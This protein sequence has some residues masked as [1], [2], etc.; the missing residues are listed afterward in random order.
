MKDPTASSRKLDHIKLAFDSAIS[1]SMLDHRF[2]YEPMLSSLPGT[3]QGDERSFG[4]KK[5]RYPIWVSSMT[6]GTE[7]AN[8]INKRL[9]K[10]CGQ[11]GLAMGLGSC[12]QLLD[13]DEYLNDFMVRDLMPDQPLFANLGIAQ[14]EELIKNKETHKI[15]QLLGKLGADGLIIHVNPLQEWLQPEGDVI[16]VAPIDTIKSILAQGK[17][18]IIVKEVGQGFGKE[19]MR[20]L[21]SLPLEAVDFA[22]NGGTNFAKIELFRSD[23]IKKEVYQ[24]VSNLGHDAETM[25]RWANELVAEGLEV[26]AKQVIISG[27]IKNFL[28]GYYHVHLSD[29]KSSYAMASGFL[30]YALESE[31]ELEHF[32]QLQLRGYDMAQAMLRINK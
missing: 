20:R 3:K 26:K 6:G 17:Y 2:I 18:P 5:T 30:K 11:Y 8:K 21:L 16:K 24:N 15:D 31:E 28:D 13:S 22:A 25:V 4:A 9:A 19:S 1:K 29:L 27:G 14:V 10:I 32:V 12:R 23:E 7:L